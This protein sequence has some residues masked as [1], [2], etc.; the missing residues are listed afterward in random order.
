MTDKQLY[1]QIGRRTKLPFTGITPIEERKKFIRHLAQQGFTAW[2]I[3]KIY[4]NM[5][6]TGIKNAINGNS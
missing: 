1:E 6:Y 3:N 5:T 4:R 2:E